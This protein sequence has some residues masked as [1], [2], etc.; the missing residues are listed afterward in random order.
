MK[1]PDTV[2]EA[3]ELLAAAGYVDDYRLC[4]K[5]IKAA[6]HDAPHPTGTAVVDYTFRFEGPSDPGDEAI[7][8]GVR[9]TEWNSQGVI[10]AAYGPDADP[11]EAAL[12]VALTRGHPDVT[13]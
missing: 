2:T 11:E 4:A 13:P 1:A 8:L 5:G 10:V 7:V 3:V 6:G 9:C 12:L